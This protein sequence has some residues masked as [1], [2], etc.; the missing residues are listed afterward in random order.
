[1][2]HLIMQLPSLKLPS[3]YLYDNRALYLI[4][5]VKLSDSWSLRIV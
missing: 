3:C 5:M 4:E 1:M 2:M